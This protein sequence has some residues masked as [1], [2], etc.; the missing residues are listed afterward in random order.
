MTFDLATDRYLSAL[1]RKKKALLARDDILAFAEMMMPDETWPDDVDFSQ[2]EVKPHH[3]AIA[4]ALE[5][6]EDGTITRIM[7]NCP[8]RHGKSQL[9]SRMF[10][11]WFI[12]RH[13]ADSLIIATY[14]ERFSWDFG[15]EVRQIMDDPI[16]RQI[17]PDIG[18]NTASV[19]RVETEDGGK[20]FFVGRGGSIT[21]R[22]A[23]GMV[24]DDPLKDRVEADSKITREKLWTWYNQV[25]KTRLLSSIG[26][27]LVISTRWHE[28]DLCGRILDPQNPSYSDAEASRWRLIDLPALAGEDD[29]LGRKRGEA[30]WPERFPVAYLEE[31]R[32]GDP[33]GFQALYQGSPTPDSGNFFPVEKIRTYGHKRER[34]PDDRLQFYAASD[35]AVSLE[36]DRD[37]SC[38]MV[39]GIDE[40]QDI[41]VM[42]D[43][44]WGR[45]PTDF[46]VERM[47]DLMKKYKIMMWTAERG[48]ISKSIGPFLRKRMMERSTFA[49][50]TEQVP[51]HDKQ[52]RAQAIQGRMHMGKIHFPSFAP[53][54]GAARDELAKFPF[55]VHDD[56]C[57]TLG[58]IGMGLA[59]HYRKAPPKP[60][61]P[62]T[63]VGTLGWIKEQSKRD[64]KER[65]ENAN[66][67]W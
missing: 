64:A 16:Y 29:V 55:G 19:D 24:I 32:A 48:H 67:G 56:L 47:V 53:W 54:W 9:T 20:L 17:F 46:V 41:W 34:P 4:A 33:R 39:V 6:V 1:K 21:G 65:R 42:E 11:A 12:G 25:A 2:Y 50:I 22:G 3:A 63:V 30:L 51:V 8:P 59:A 27:I 40:D 14:S 60:K 37:K 28:D 66:G 13:P 23:V 31:L 5:K 15:R 52:T 35:H 62:E 26:W 43:L 44:V 49:A 38:L 36:Q 45:Y 61:P 7:I 18:L 57:D 10:P 58:W